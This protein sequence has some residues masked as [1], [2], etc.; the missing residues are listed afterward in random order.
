MTSFISGNQVLLVYCRSEK[1][2]DYL[3]ETKTIGTVFATRIDALKTYN[4][5]DITRFVKF[6]TKSFEAEDVTE[7]MARSY[8]WSTGMTVALGDESCFPLFV[9]ACEDEVEIWRENERAV[10]GF[11]S[12]QYSTLDHRTQGLTGAVMS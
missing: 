3:S 5:D 2:G 1:F 11:R 4:D 6:D 7:D 10:I 8:L 9:K 12:G